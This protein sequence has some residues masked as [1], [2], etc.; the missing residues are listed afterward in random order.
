MMSQEKKAPA[1]ETAMVSWFNARQ[2]YGRAVTRSGEK[3]VINMNA[4]REVKDGDHGPFLSDKA[5]DRIPEVGEEIKFVRNPRHQS[6]AA[7]WGY[8]RFWDDE[9]VEALTS[10]PVAPPA[11]AKPENKARPTRHGHPKPVLAPV[12]TELDRELGLMPKKEMDEL[13]ALARGVNGRNHGKRQRAF[14]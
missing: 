12:I 6:I 1:V 2:G 9:A 7:C 10:A 14:A 11:P 5:F 3:I 4:C 13:E 8:K